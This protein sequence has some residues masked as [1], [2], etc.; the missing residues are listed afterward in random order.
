MT[1]PVMFDE[2]D[3]D[4]MFT[5]GQIERAWL[6]YCNEKDRVLSYVD[7]GFID[8]LHNIIQERPE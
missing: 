7:T 3:T 8:F 4:Y 1:E 6:V 2:E 5:I